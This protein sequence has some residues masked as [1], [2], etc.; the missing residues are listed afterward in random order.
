MLSLTNFKMYATITNMAKDLYHN[1]IKHA[2]L[3]IKH[4]FGHGRLEKDGWT[5]TH[6]PLTIFY[7]AER[8][9]VDLGAE[10]LFAA[11]KNATRIAVEVKSFLSASSLTDLHNALGQ[12]SM[13]EALLEIEDPER[14]LVLAIPTSAEPVFQRPLGQLLIKRFQLRIMIVDTDQEV[15]ESWIPNPPT[16]NLP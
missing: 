8:L 2:F 13:Y 16:H 10:Q 15:I 5:I 1:A 14:S 11:Q 6:D 7:E 3:T 9:Y 4:T 12:Y